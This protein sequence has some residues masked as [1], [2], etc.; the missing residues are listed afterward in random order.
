MLTQI[1]RSRSS[2]LVSEVHSLSNSPLEDHLNIVEGE[3]YEKT[4]QTAQSC[5]CSI[6]MIVQLEDLC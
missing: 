3:Q 5:L 1:S 6:V 4:K 2:F